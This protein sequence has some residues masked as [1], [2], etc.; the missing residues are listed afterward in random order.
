ML[1]LYTG[2]DRDR[3][4]GAMNTDI[5]RAAK[6]DRAGVLRIT[7]ANTLEDLRA[8]LSGPGMFTSQAGGTRVLIL[9]GV[10]T[11]DEM[12]PM[13]IEALPVLSKSDDL[14][15]VYEEKPK[16]DVRRKIEKYAGRTVRH[17]APGKGRD[18]TIFA[19][20]TALSRGD[21]KSLWVGYQR[22]L[23][24]GE[25]P[26]AIHGVLFWGAKKTLL[27]ARK[28]SADYTRGASLVTDL[29]ELPHKARRQGFELEYALEHYVLSL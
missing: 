22:A 4:R 26:E 21:R 16:A 17:D 20:A 19:L 7:D 5:E 18:N 11:N 10:L 8:A 23:A 27:S 15:F 6:E 1:Y 9:E 13:L 14:V 25:R 3:A 12:Y 24:R 28:G 2:T 29:A